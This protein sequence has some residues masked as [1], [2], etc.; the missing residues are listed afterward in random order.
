MYFKTL[1]FRISVVGFVSIN[2]T[3]IFH[4]FFNFWRICSDSLSFVPDTGHLCFLLFLPI[5]LAWV[6]S[7]LLIFSNNQLLV[8]LI[9]LFPYS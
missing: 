3:I 7:N 6:L 5:T 9:F 8:L 2:V 4:C 1:V